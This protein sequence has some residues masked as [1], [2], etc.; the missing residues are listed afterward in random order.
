MGEVGGGGEGGERRSDAR[1]AGGAGDVADAGRENAN[2][3]SIDR[4]GRRAGEGR[5]EAGSH[6]ANASSASTCAGVPAIARSPSRS[7]APRAVVSTA[8]RASIRALIPS[9]SAKIS[10]TTGTLP[11][12]YRTATSAA[13]AEGGRSTIRLIVGHHH[14]AAT[15]ALSLLPLILP[16]PHTLCLRALAARAAGC[17]RRERII[18]TKVRRSEIRTAA[19]ARSPRSPAL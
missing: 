7:S 2:D 6:L 15:R 12:R 10:T 9:A 8:D 14:P 18:N 11:D 16:T 17:R 5:A 19:A 1:G 13:T 3:R 4:A